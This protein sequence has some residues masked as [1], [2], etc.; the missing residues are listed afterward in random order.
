[1]LANACN[2]GMWVWGNG[3]CMSQ[4]SHCCPIDRLSNHGAHAGEVRADLYIRKTQDGEA[5]AVENGGT[6]GVIRLSG[7]RE[8]R[9]TI[10]LDDECSLRD[11][12][13]NNEMM[14]WSLPPDADR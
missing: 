10:D 4:P 12:E 6:L 13:I 3:V 11:V 7:G 1:M 2:N 14:D 8:M 5:V 9:F